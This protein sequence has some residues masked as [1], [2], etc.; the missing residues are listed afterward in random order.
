MSISGLSLSE[1]ASFFKQN[2]ITL[3]PH[4]IYNSIPFD[5]FEPDYDLEK[6]LRKY[7]E[8]LNKKLVNGFESG[9]MASI[10]DAI[11]MYIQVNTK[12]KLWNHPICTLKVIEIFAKLTC[13][14]DLLES[15]V[16]SKLAYL[17][18]K[19]V[20]QA[21]KQD[22]VWKNYPANLISWTQ[23]R[24]LLD[25]VLFPSKM[26]T[27]RLKLEVDHFGNIAQLTESL[28]SKMGDEEAILQHYLPSILSYADQ[29][30]H[31]RALGHVILFVAFKKP[32][33]CKLFIDAIF[34]REPFRLLYLRHGVTDQCV[35][36]CL[37][38]VA[39]H[40]PEL[41]TNDMFTVVMST[42]LKHC[43]N[44]GMLAQ[45]NIYHF[46][47]NP[48]WINAVK[49]ILDSILNKNSIW[50]CCGRFASRLI[51]YNE[52]AQEVF[53]R[54]L[55][56]GQL[57]T[58]FL[59]NTLAWMVTLREDPKE[60]HSS[61]IILPSNESFL[62]AAWQSCLL[63]IT[64]EFKQN[65]LFTNNEKRTPITGPLKYLFQLCPERLF[66][67]Y[68]KL[69]IAMTQEAI[70]DSNSQ[71]KANC[72]LFVIA[73]CLDVPGFANLAR[74]LTTNILNNNPFNT[75]N[76]AATG[77]ASLL[78]FLHK[79]DI[80]SPTVF[81]EQFLAFSKCLGIKDA[82][83]DMDA[84]PQKVDDFEAIKMEKFDFIVFRLCNLM[85][86]R[87]FH[88][89]PGCPELLENIVY[90]GD[91][92]YPSHIVGLVLS[93]INVDVSSQV[94]LEALK[95]YLK[96]GVGLEEDQSNAQNERFMYVLECTE[97]FLTS[98]SLKDLYHVKRNKLLSECLLQCLTSCKHIKVFSRACT[99]MSCLLKN[100]LKLTIAIPW[101]SSNTISFQGDQNDALFD[102]FFS[103]KSGENGDL[104]QRLVSLAKGLLTDSVNKW[105][106][107]RE[108]ILFADCDLIEE[109]EIDF[110]PSLSLSDDN[111]ISDTSSTRLMALQAESLAA[112]AFR[113]FI[114]H[115]DTYEHSR[116]VCKDLRSMFFKLH[117]KD[118]SQP[119]FLAALR[120]EHLLKERQVFWKAAEDPKLPDAVFSLIS[121][122]YD[123]LRL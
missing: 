88:N 21:K 10:Y 12:L 73:Q 106:L 59:A 122:P 33:T 97:V 85:L 15:S 120:I 22:G 119:A 96:H 90:I 93:L 25:Y 24:D 111:S 51:T 45:D 75:N 107:T 61:H 19:F 87:S 82:T 113:K 55:N 18:S 81:L 67:R 43:K 13:R 89:V 108:L 76:L 94:L 79:P 123:F 65:G 70:C 105:L 28:A 84:N 86:R 80:D 53:T 118:H 39:K 72:F 5:K 8:V 62:E 11:Q 16:R 37:T 77:L 35:L 121:S 6:D 52:G 57:N 99:A 114:F 38:K 7:A 102:N 101:V 46:M 98:I 95:K 64:M 91:N 50:D 4:Y 49:R 36:I 109:L 116:F 41:I 47:H 17:T 74:D 31:I 78:M 100:D 54:A 20:H 9:K 30:Q 92:T 2:L 66:K 71:V 1:V 56:S 40:H 103:F 58:E 112:S 3:T 83:R 26:E 44:P 117:P 63:Q 115:D 23:F 68:S 14:R 48:V 110:L 34:A 104:N 60:K 27:Q 42:I 32:S 29:D 69:L